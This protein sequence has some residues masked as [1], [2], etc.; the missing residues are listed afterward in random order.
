[1]PRRSLATSPIDKHDHLPIDKHDHSFHA[2]HETM[3][4]RRPASPRAPRR[5]GPAG[6]PRQAR[7][8][9]PKAHTRAIGRQAALRRPRCT[10]SIVLLGA[11]ARPRGAA[12]CAARQ[13]PGNGRIRVAAPAAMQA[14]TLAVAAAAGYAPPPLPDARRDL[15]FVQRVVRVPASPRRAARGSACRLRRSTRAC[16]IRLRRA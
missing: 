16:P 1:M 5:H 6:L 4:H 11:S 3:P 9:A 13:G 15:F 8:A 10:R 7:S 2:S 14:P 12:R